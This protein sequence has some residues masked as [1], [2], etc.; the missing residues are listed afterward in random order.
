MGTAL[1][2]E[3]KTMKEHGMLFKTNMVQ[4]ILN[5]K[6]TQT[7]RVITRMNANVDGQAWEIHQRSL[8]IF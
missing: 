1:Y 4:A 5:G 2:S 6:K 8:G 7:R 3:R